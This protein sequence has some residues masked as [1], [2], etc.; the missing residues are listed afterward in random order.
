MDQLRIQIIKMESDENSYEKEIRQD[1][2]KL[3]ILHL[4]LNQAQMVEVIRLS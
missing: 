4:R 1:L 2:R 3:T